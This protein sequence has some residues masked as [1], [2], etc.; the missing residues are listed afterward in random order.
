MAGDNGGVG[1]GSPATVQE[2]ELRREKSMGIMSQRFLMLFLTSPPK[3]VSLDLA[4]KVLIGDPT[5]D[6]TQSLVYK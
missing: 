5:V 3:T 6:K 4:A 2:V 1:G